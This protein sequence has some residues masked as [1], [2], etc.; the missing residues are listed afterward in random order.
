MFVRFGWFRFA[1]AQRPVRRIS[2]SRVA[3]PLALA[4]AL[5]LALVL[6]QALT[7]ARLGAG[8]LLRALWA[9]EKAVGGG[10]G[11]LRHGGG[12]AFVAPRG[13]RAVANG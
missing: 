3:A 6:V 7:L 12:T 13:A 2:H 4:S 10:A 8:S 5:A 11:G 9:G 1:V